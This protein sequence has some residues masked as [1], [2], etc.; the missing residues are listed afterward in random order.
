L[1]LKTCERDI[2]PAFSTTPMPYLLER[3]DYEPGTGCDK[4][5]ILRIAQD[6]LLTKANANTVVANGVSV[7]LDPTE[8]AITPLTDGIAAK[9]QEYCACGV[10]WTS[11][12]RETFKSPC[13][14]GTCEDVSWL[15]QSIGK[16]VYVTL[17]FQPVSSPF[18][19]RFG[20]FPS[21]AKAAAKS[22]LQRLLSGKAE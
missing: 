16:P 22:C 19:A 20:Q 9:L 3:T 14:A 6:G 21:L 17:R 15:R 2:S 11:G 7:M 8:M 1:D 5:P 10:T 13:P 18:P 4:S 12:Q